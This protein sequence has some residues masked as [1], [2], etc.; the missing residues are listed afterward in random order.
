VRRWQPGQGAHR[1]NTQGGGGL[2]LWRRSHN[3]AGGAAVFSA[4][5]LV[6]SLVSCCR[7]EHSAEC[8]ENRC[9]IRLH[10]NRVHHLANWIFMKS[11]ECVVRLEHSLNTTATHR[12]SYPLLPQFPTAHC[13]F[14]GDASFCAEQ[15]MDSPLAT[16]GWQSLRVFLDTGFL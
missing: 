15:V 11:S 3:S 8:F 14:L 13:T 7:R 10:T 5:G 4:H 6:S 16:A 2:R 1:E 12:R 9:A